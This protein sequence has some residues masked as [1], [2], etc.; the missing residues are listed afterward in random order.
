[1]GGWG[2]GI[3]SFMDT[4]DADDRKRRDEVIRIFYHGSLIVVY[5]RG[6]FRI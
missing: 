5:E 4:D 1:M 3:E 2:K 6:V